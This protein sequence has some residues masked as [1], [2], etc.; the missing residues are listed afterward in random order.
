[1]SL[2]SS[3][4]ACHLLHA[5]LLLGLFFDP[6]DGDDMLLFNGL[7][8]VRGVR[9]SVVGGGTM[10]QAGKSRVR[11]TMRLLDF[12]IGLILPAVLWSWGRLCL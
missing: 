8:S 4:F 9:G 1:M 2:P 11:I 5:G 7:H 10:L 3:G 12:S 6:E